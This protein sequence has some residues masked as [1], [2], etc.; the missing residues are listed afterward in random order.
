M[1]DTTEAP[2]DDL[3]ADIGAAW[4]EIVAREEGGATDRD[5]RG[6]FAARDSGEKAETET[7][8]APEQSAP[9]SDAPSHW[10]E[11]EKA[12]W[13]TLAPEAQRA[14]LRRERDIENAA[15]ERDETARRYQ[16]IDEVIAPHR[17][18][19]A[20]AGVQPQEAIRQLLAAQDAL[21]TNFD[22]ALPALIR[23]FGRDPVAMAY[24]LLGAN[25]QAA[26]DGQQGHN[27]PARDPRLDE[28]YNW[29][30]QQERA[31]AQQLEQQ[32]LAAIKEVSDQ[33]ET[34][35]RDP[36]YPHFETVRHDM[37]AMFQV[38]PNMTLKDAYERAV[39]ANPT[40]RATLMAQAQV[41]PAKAT[42]KP[43]SIRDTPSQAG[44]ARSVNRDGWTT[45]DYLREAWDQQTAA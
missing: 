3:S 24:A 8:A 26:L 39:W 35:S 6:R 15:R 37:G 29:K 25:S 14:V 16:P 30:Q 27:L 41:Q 18:K 5:D 21:T 13:A 17:D 45:E 36:A 32:H 34:F 43:T 12:H 28:L 1:S 22:G 31:T 7:K 23:A 38:N 9:A 20:V 11:D 44:A 2:A 19:W 40:T 42:S 33:I 10:A 4:D